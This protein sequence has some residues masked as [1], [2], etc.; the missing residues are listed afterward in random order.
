MKKGLM[1]DTEK[2]ICDAKNNSGLSAYSLSKKHGYCENYLS[3]INSQKR[4]IGKE[5]F[6]EVC[7]TYGLSPFDYLLEKQANNTAP[8]KNN[9]RPRHFSTLPEEEMHRIAK[10]GAQKSAE[11]RRKKKAMKEG[12]DIPI[13]SD[14]KLDRVIE[15]L[16]QIANQ[17][18]LEWFR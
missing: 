10:L 1:I 2:F 8:A 7:A 5:F 6:Y 14:A 16:E 15:L 4:S 12:D 18:K 17:T 3:F 13:A 9:K 11:V